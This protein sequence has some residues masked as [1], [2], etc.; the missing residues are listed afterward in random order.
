MGYTT[1]YKLGVENGTQEQADA[2]LEELCE[3]DED[4]AWAFGDSGTT[5]WD[6]MDDDMKAFSLKHPGVVIWVRW[7]G[8]ETDD[9]GYAYYKDGKMQSCPVQISYDE[10]DESKLQ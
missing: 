8:D 5:G 4:I 10:Y 1:Y 7:D 2:L 6:S 9:M 3:S